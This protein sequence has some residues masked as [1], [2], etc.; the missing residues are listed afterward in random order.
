ME[1]EQCL[2]LCHRSPYHTVRIKPSPRAYKLQEKRYISSYIVSE[3]GQ[4]HIEKDAIYLGTRFRPRFS[5]SIRQPFFFD[6]RITLR[7]HLSTTSRPAESLNLL[8]LLS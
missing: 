2:I 4:T 7:E 6:L 8:P 5:L 1:E 3:L